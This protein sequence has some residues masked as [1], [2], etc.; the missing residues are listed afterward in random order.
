MANRCLASLPPCLIPLSPHGG[1]QRRI[2]PKRCE[3]RSRWPSSD[4]Q[5]PRAAGD[6]GVEEVSLQHGIMLGRNADYPGWILRTLALMDSD[7]I[8]GD[9]GV[10]FTEAIGH[11]APS[12]VATSSP[13]SGS[14][15]TTWPM[16]P[17][18]TS[19]P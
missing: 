11:R 4:R 5:G 15:L 3:P 18:W 16:S 9:Q 17:L 6:A 7:G 19:L 1:R 12:K 2:E 13:V 10:K 14:T 8:S